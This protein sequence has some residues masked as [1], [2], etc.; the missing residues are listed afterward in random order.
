MK[1]DCVKILGVLSDYRDGSLAEPERR[2][3]HLHLGDCPP[4]KGLFEDLDLIVVAARGLRSDEDGISYPD[5]NV[6]WQRMAVIK[7]PVH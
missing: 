5:E 3:V 1:D 4:C 6:I 2:L 7:P